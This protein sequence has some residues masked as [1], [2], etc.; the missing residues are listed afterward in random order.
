MTNCHHILAIMA[1]LLV[2]SCSG[3]GNQGASL[4]DY[5]NASASGKMRNFE[6]YVNGLF[7]LDPVQAQEVQREV[8]ADASADSA[9]WRSLLELENTF[10]N[11]PN[12]PY[13]CEDLYLPVLLAIASSPFSTEGEIAD[14][15]YN[16]PRYM[17]N[18]LGEKVADFEFTLRNGRT[19]TLSSVEAEHIILFFSNPGCENCKEVMNQICG[20]PF[21]QE[22]IEDGSLAIVNIYPDDDMEAWLE[23]VAAYP[24][25]WISGFAPG[26]DD[27]TDATPA[28]Y[29][30]RAIP[31]LYLLD[32][33]HRLL[34]KDAPLERI[35]SYLYAI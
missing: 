22:M 33:E 2:V 8:L 9:A 18:P 28:K 13:R 1:T 24:K 23:Y 3:G 21:V 7:A 31:T 17:I 11:D 20:T 30:I 12:S 25:E 27:W 19:R 6:K 14:A 4:A 15:V 32:S 5:S 29:N 16:I 26:I 34:M 10:L 35:V